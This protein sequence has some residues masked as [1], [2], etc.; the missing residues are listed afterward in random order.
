[1]YTKTEKE[2]ASILTDIILTYNFKNVTLFQ[3]S[4]CFYANIY[5]IRNITRNIVNKVNLRYY[6]EFNYVQITKFKH[7]RK[8]RRDKLRQRTVLFERNGIARRLFT[9]FVYE[10]ANLSRLP[11]NKGM[12]PRIYGVCKRSRHQKHREQI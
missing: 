6:L 2:L 5:K 7:Y 10:R 8:K 12:R 11:F 3:T 1:M 9:H 4:N